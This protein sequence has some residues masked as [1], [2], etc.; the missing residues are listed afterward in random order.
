MLLYWAGLALAEPPKVNA[1]LKQFFVASA[2]Y[3]HLLMPPD[4]YGQAFVDGRL[5]VRWDIADNLRVEAHHAVTAGTPAPVSSLVSELD[6]MGLGDEGGEAGGALMSGVGLQAPEAVELSW[7]AFDDSELMMQGRTDRLFVHASFGPVDM[8]LG[9]QAVGFGH[10]LAFNPMDLV[11]PFSFATIDSEYKP[12]IDA[13]RLDGY[14]GMSAHATA[15]VAY[16]GDWD[17]EGMIAMFHASTTLGLSDLSLFYGAVRGDDVIGGGISS[18][19]GPVGVH[20]DA[21]ATF[22]RD[23]GEE[24]FYRAVAGFFHKPFERSTLSG[25]LYL[26][27]VGAEEP[28]D[29][30]EF[31]SSDRFARGEIWLLGR[32][33]AMASWGQELTPLVSGTLSS[34]VNLGDGSA[35]LGPSVSIS[36]SDDVQAVLGGFLGLGERPPEVSFDEILLGEELGL[37]SEFGMNPPMAFVQ[38]RAYF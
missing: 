29:Y 16:A 4:A 5:K 10:G 37:G 1:D 8:R 9:R 13:L 24:P 34:T 15:V 18:S 33:Y 7:A 12:G 3:E 38:M 2:P 31:A 14:F 19:I 25:E 28:G 20:A 11:Q 6:S 27:T 17:A 30:L 32:Y 21:T 23:S 35:F 26:Q 22:P 36:V